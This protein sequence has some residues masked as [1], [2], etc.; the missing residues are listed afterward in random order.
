MRGASL[1]E[2]L[3]LLV[4]H[5]V[6]TKATCPGMSPAAGLGRVRRGP[7]R[8]PAVRTRLTL[9]LAGFMVAGCASAAVPSIAPS[10]AEPSVTPASAPPTTTPA[11]SLTDAQA[12]DEDLAAL[13]KGVRDSHPNPFAIH[14][15]SEWTAELAALP[16]ELANATPE[17][18]LVRLSRLV[19][20]LD[21][22]SGIT[23]PF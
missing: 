18:Q 9:L 13:D 1:R 6:G 4:P 14:P 22:H 23:P 8:A 7:M 15:E 3:G 12:W 11:P 10:P 19:G 17:Q 5:P 16:A 21:T 2:R 20:L